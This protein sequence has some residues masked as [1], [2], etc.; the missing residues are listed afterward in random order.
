[1]ANE[2]PTPASA[3]YSAPTSGQPPSGGQATR[4][5]ST[6]TPTRRPG[7]PSSNFHDRQGSSLP[8]GRPWGWRI[9]S[10][11]SLRPGWRPRVAVRLQPLDRDHRHVAGPGT[12][13]LPSPGTCPPDYTSLRH[14]PD[15]SL[16]CARRAPGSA[17]APAPGDTHLDA[18]VPAGWRLGQRLPR[19]CLQH[20]G[21]DPTPLRLGDRLRC[22]VPH[23]SHDRHALSLSSPPPLSPILD[24]RWKRFHS[25][26]HLSRCLGSPWA[27]LP[28]R[29]SRS[30][31]HHSQSSFC[32][33][34]HH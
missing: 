19:C 34:I 25:A 4:P 13:C 17:R 12:Q 30:S 11:W 21:D 27:V 3:L 20:H 15:A 10:W 31:P 28:Q 5:P 7:G 29:C 6:G 22:L 26:S 23:H 18:L 16:R 32:S 33:S 2:A 24:R 14:A 9:L 1:M 8:Q